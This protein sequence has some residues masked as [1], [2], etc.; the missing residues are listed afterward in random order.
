LKRTLT[1]SHFETKNLK[2]FNI[3]EEEYRENE[4]TGERKKVLETY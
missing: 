4:E 3:E 1:L 2:G